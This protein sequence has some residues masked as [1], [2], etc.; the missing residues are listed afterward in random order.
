MSSKK[1]SLLRKQA[2]I[3]VPVTWNY[4]PD[5]RWW[6]DVGTRGI[7]SDCA[8]LEEAITAI[9][10]A[11]AQLWPVALDEWEEASGKTIRMPRPPPPVCTDPHTDPQDTVVVDIY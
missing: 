4:D 3:D 7:S 5:G 11:V 2:V 6:C 1:P 9:N 8:S 10:R